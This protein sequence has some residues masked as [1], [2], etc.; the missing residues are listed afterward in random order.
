MTKYKV[1]SKSLLKRWEPCTLLPTKIQ[2]LL[3]GK[4]RRWKSG[5]ILDFGVCVFQQ[6]RNENPHFE[7][8]MMKTGSEGENETERKQHDHFIRR[9]DSSRSPLSLRGGGMCRSPQ[10]SGGPTDKLMS[11]RWHGRDTQTI[12]S[13][14]GF[15]DLYIVG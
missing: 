10:G 9:V 7:S 2:K 12:F 1:I 5:V 4:R 13:S 8:L 11:I 15:L 14:H 6:R 3:D